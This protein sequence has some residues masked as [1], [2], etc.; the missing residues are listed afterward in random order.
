MSENKEK[1][2]LKVFT[3][4][5]GKYI[6]VDNDKDFSFEFPTNSNLEKNL[7]I[8]TFIKFEMK[9]AIL[10]AKAKQEAALKAAETQSKEEAKAVIE[11][12]EEELKENIEK[13]NQ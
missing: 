13:A 12:T 11:M 4:Y 1:K 10:E 7:E 6:V 2:E 8:I 5:K 3:N 9:K